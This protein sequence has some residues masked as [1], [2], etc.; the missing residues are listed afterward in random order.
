MN[1]FLLPHLKPVA[2]GSV[3]LVE[4]WALVFYSLDGVGCGYENKRSA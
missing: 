2:R 4:V 1:V 3:T